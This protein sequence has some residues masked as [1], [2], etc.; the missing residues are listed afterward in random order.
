MA[1]DSAIEWTDATWNPVTGCT[2]ISPGC[3]FCYAERLTERFGRQPF[4]EIR[5]HP[6]RLSL[7]LRWRGSR[8]I[9]V[10]SMSDLF[11]EKVP[12][13]FI[14]QVFDVMARA[15]QHVFQVLTKRPERLL[16]WHRA[17]AWPRPFPEHVWL[18][19]S[20]E[21]A[22]Y[23][24]RVDRLREVDVAVRFVSAEPLLGPLTHLDLDGIAWVI[25]GGESGG[26]PERALV[27]RTERGVRPKPQGV[28][29]VR[30]IRNLCRSQ[31]V[32]FFHKQWGGRTPKSGGRLLDGR[33]WSQYPPLGAIALNRLTATR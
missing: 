15:P 30:Q 16:E 11:H 1:L 20:V 31:G 25:T 3:K 4:T 13:D 2:K 18:G 29:W 23:L 7:P 26:P 22:A 17:R 28:R 6:E 19:V 10:N 12:A 24:W 5:L 33:E 21:S 27:E 14:S 32:A 8:R 9:F